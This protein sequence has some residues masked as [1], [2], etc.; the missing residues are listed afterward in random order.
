L[1]LG[2]PPL[3]FGTLTAVQLGYSAVCRAPRETRRHLPAD[4]E[5]RLP[6]FI[7]GATAVHIAALTLP[8]LRRVLGLPAPTAL[9]FGG[10]AV[11]LVL[12]ALMG[13]M[14]TW[15]GR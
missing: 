2:G 8:P 14:P 6:V 7:G 1:A 11:G 10:L 5:W 13:A 9:T 3:A 15:S 12:P 4:G